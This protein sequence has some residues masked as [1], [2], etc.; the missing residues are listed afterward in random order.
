[1]NMFT[2]KVKEKLRAGGTAWGSSTMGTDPLGAKLVATTGVDFVWIDTEHSSHGAESIELMPPLIRQSGVMPLVRV[3]I[4]DPALL[5]KALD[6]GAQAVMIPQVDNAA[7]AALA[8]KYSKYPPQGSRGISPMWT[9]Y[10]DVDWKPYLPA[11]NDET[12]VI[13]QVESPEAVSQV[14]A[15]AQVDGVDVVFAGPMDLS[16]ALGHIGEIGHPDV[17]QFL[18]GFPARVTKYGKTAGIA[19]GSYEAAAKAWTQGYRFINFGNLYFDGYH[20]IKANL[21]RLQALEQSGS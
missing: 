21:A 18:A 17:Q 15:M 3:A 6:I 9:F 7:Q 10:N 2:N 8:V 4:L 11:A 5:K 12:M 19:V 16:A 14:E 20:G 13:V 1:M